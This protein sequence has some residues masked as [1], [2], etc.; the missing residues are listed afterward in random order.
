V[1]AKR[2]VGVLLLPFELDRLGIRRD[3]TEFEVIE[4]GR[5]EPDDIPNLLIRV[6]V[7]LAHA[8]EEGGEIL[9]IRPEGFVIVDGSLSPDAGREARVMKMVDDPARNRLVHIM[10]DAAIRAPFT[11]LVLEGFELGLCVTG[12]KGDAVVTRVAMKD[13]DFFRER[14][15]VVQCGDEG[16]LVPV[17]AEQQLRAK[18]F[19]N[20]WSQIE[21]GISAAFGGGKRDL[22]TLVDELAQETKERDE[23]TLA[24]AVRPDEDV[25]GGEFEIPQ[26]S[27][28]LKSFNRQA[29]DR[30]AHP[31]C[32]RS[33]QAS[34]FSTIP[35]FNRSRSAAS[36]RALGKCSGE[37]EACGQTRGSAE[38]RCSSV[39]GLLVV[40]WGIGV[41]S[42]NVVDPEILDY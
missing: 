17:P 23:I 37:F 9:G 13:G 25:N 21:A 20:A 19:C 24:R 36:F 30:I 29:L 4:E 15:L 28:G 39:R 16:E 3:R 12:A 10:R 34:C 2:V 32:P 7:G 5:G 35:C 22:E 41:D 33:Q 38:F 1:R 27:Y 6:P 8:I 11:F 26:R 14:E 31:L 18:C 40:S 42:G